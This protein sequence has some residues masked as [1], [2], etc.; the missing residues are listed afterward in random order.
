MSKRD[1]V[2]HIADESMEKGFKAFF[3]RVDWNYA[4]KCNRFDIDPD[5]DRD[6]FR[7]SGH[8]SDLNPRRNDPGMH[9]HAHDNLRTHLDTHEKAIIILDE[10]YGGSP[11]A[12]ALRE[13][14]TVNMMEAGWDKD[15]FEVVVIQPMLEA[16][17]W[18]NN[19]NVAKAFGFESFEELQQPLVE[20]GLWVKGQPKPIDDKMKDAKN[21]AI[22]IGKHSR[23]KGHKKLPSS[24]FSSLFKQISSKACDACKEPGF[25]Q[26][27]TRLQEWFPADGGAL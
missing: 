3:R 1:I 11:G 25:Q 13:E 23:Q 18:A 27:R 10:F 6:I 2:F 12:D 14:I 7:I 20:K 16:W 15:R 17:I 5:S 19:L 21:V 9:H 22:Q 24:P 8:D 4:L 26:M